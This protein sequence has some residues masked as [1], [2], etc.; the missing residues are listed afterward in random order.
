MGQADRRGVIRLKGFVLLHCGMI[1]IWGVCNGYNWATGLHSQLKVSVEALCFY[2]T[3]PLQLWSQSRWDN[4]QAC[5]RVFAA[6]LFACVC[7]HRAAYVRIL[8]LPPYVSSRSDEREIDRPPQ[9]MC[10]WQRKVSSLPWHITHVPPVILLFLQ[11]SCHLSELWEISEK[12]PNQA[13]KPQCS[14]LWSSVCVCVVYSH[15]AHNSSLFSSLLSFFDLYSSSFFFLSSLTSLNHLSLLFYL[16]PYFCFSF[17]V[18]FSASSLL[19]EQLNTRLKSRVL[20]ATL[21]KSFKSEA[22]L[23][24]ITAACD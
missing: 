3:C 12:I 21:G 17:S 4:Y 1:R 11:I 10:W 20:Q 5:R 23:T 22:S 7:C 16:L 2:V 14:G 19:K 8:P 15:P 24:S 9:Q 6:V 13:D 18:S